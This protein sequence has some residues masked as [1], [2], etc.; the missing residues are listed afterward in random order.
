MMC[1]DIEELR[2]KIDEYFDTVTPEQLH[3]DCIAA[4]LEFYQGDEF[5]FLDDLVIQE[6]SG[7]KG[8]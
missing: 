5:N 8:E 7:A 4:G 1:L 3:K 6:T 2:R